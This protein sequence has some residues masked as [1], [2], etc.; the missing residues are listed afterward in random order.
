MNSRLDPIQAA[1]LRTKLKYLNDSTNRRKK[2]ADIYDSLLPGI[3]QIEIP[4]RTNYS[5]HVFHQYTIKV[6]NGK[7]DDLKL[8][9]G[10]LGIPSMVYYPHPLHKQPAYSHFNTEPLS[11]SESLS[12]EVLS[13]HMHTEL[14]V[15]HQEFITESI[16]KFFEVHG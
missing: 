5:E 7:R 15:S 3:D 16:S 10:D 14:T 6:K 11:V 4:E 1:T 13:L 9:L 2:A 8:Y 12:N